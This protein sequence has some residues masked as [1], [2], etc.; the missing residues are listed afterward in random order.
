MAAQRPTRDQGYRRQRPEGWPVGSFE[1]YEQAQAAVEMLTKDDSFP[2]AE[3]TIV[4]VDL[5]EVERVV[6]R[7]SWGKVLV[8]GAL[9][10]IWMGAF[11]GLLMGYFNENWVGPLIAG[12]VM[13]VIFG[14]TSSSVSYAA[15]KKS[16]DFSTT[17]EIVAGRYDVLC[18]PPHARQA[19]D[20]IARAHL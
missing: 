11:F 3:L 5:M 15:S 7:L 2:V 20:M 9:S 4:G 6:G 12:V 16:R 10:G 14:V 19:R 13:G 17:T 8:S 1:T 18:S